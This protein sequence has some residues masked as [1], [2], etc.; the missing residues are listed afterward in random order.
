MKWLS[1]IMGG[2]CSFALVDAAWADAVNT[3]PAEILGSDLQDAMDAITVSGPGINVYTDQDP[4]ARFTN[5]ASGG[6]V[7]TFIVEVTGFGDTNEFGIYD[8]VDPTKKAKIFDGSDSAGSIK[9]V[10]FMANG[11]IRVNFVTVATGFASPGNFGF[12]VDVFEAPLGAGGDGDSSKLDYTNYTEDSLNQGGATQAVL[13]Q[14]DD[15][16]TL[17]IAPFSPGLFT[18]NQFILAFEDLLLAPG[19][20]GCDS[21]SD[22]S[23]SDLVVLVESIA[24]VPAP[25][26]ALLASMGLSMVAWRRRRWS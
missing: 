2:M 19:C 23:Y 24:P 5:T 17:G 16:T 13:F 20:V 22:R 15:E 3:R 10:S 21:V 1:V 18:S 26:A 6:A 25:G 11:D 4:F 7:A 9:L 14:G 12:Y 8:S